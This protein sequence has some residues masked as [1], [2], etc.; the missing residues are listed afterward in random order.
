MIAHYSCVLKFPLKTMCPYSE[1]VQVI[2][3][4]SVSVGDDIVAKMNY[5]NIVFFVNS[6]NIEQYSASV[7]GDNDA[8]ITNSNMKSLS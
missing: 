3:H 6:C 2:G 4:Y 1:Q 5:F 7:G 8:K